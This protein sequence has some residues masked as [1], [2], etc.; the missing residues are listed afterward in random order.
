MIVDMQD[1]FSSSRNSQV[2]KNCVREIKSA[3]RREADIIFV[4]YDGCGDTL[5]ILKKAAGKYKKVH[6]VIKYHDDGGPE[7]ISKIDEAR[8]SK[9]IRACGVNTDACVLST[10]T[11]L[12]YTNKLKIKVVAD[13]CNTDFVFCHKDALR[14]MRILPGCKVI[15]A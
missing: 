11:S 3:I 10:I 9:Q 14:R 5:P 4:E 2:Q 8:L 13:A 6:H 15:R 7:V 12:S 1:Q